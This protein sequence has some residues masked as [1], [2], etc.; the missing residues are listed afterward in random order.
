MIENWIH[1]IVGEEKKN[2]N[3]WK[4]DERNQQLG[5]LAVYVDI[6][7]YTDIDLY[8]EWR[9]TYTSISAQILM[10]KAHSQL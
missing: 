7:I 4:T 1:M 6:A 9:S 10:L 2:K 3:R 5:Q 8:N